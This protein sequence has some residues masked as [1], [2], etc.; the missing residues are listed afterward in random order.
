M[1]PDPPVTTPAARGREL[2]FDREASRGEL[3]LLELANLFVKRWRLVLGVPL[4]TVCVTGGISLMVPRTYTATTTFV[5]EAKSETRLPSTLAGLAGQLGV[6]VGVEP[7]Q[8][9]RFYSEVLRSRELLE[10]I[11]LARYAD[12]RVAKGAADSTAL[13]DLLPIDGRGPLDS[14]AQGVS[15]LDELIAVR[16]DPQT[17]IVRVSVD[18]R[19]PTLAAAVANRLVA[20]LN[21]FNTLK[22]QSRARQRRRFT[23][24]RVAAA[25]SELQHAEAAVKTFYERNRGW[26]QAPELVFEEARLRRLVN[27][28]QEL[29]LT[30]KREY[31]TARVEEVN[32]TPVM[33]VI[34]P[35][36][37]PQRASQ[38]RPELWM[39]VAALVGGVLSLSAA[40]VAQYLERAR[41]SGEPA[42]REL[43]VLWR[44]TGGRIGHALRRLVRSGPTP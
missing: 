33:T 15:K 2:P 16:V 20:Y 22:R 41:D 4:L 28:G 11:L 42:Y 27:V 37:A 18:A 40:L 13:L 17:N 26:Q 8:S 5:P 24:L 10:R 30:L 25:D 1:V 3:S 23:E 34:D 38:P 19:Y 12:P 14:L 35:A 29:Y 39:L 31:E 32:D 43:D 9:P 6:S 7:S 44:R 21:E 36:V